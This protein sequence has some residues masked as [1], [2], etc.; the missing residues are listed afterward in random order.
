MRI[1]T[2][3]IILPLFLLLLAQYGWVQAAPSRYDCLVK[4]GNNA[5]KEDIDSCVRGDSTPT[6]SS[7]QTSS[8]DTNAEEATCLDLGFKKKTASYA[9]CVLELLERKENSTVSN[10]PDDATCRKYGFKRKTNEYAICRQQI[11]Q[12]R[13]QEKQRQAQFNAQQAQY[14]EQLAAYKKQKSEAAGL[15]LMGM[16][17][18][19]MSNT[20]PMY[21]GSAPIAPT[22]PQIGPRTYM[23]PGN[24]MMT[25]NTT[26]NITNCF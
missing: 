26:G 17:L 20:S 15:A 16:G 25:C 2:I 4:L 1:T 14:Q 19:M 8:I 24:K 3:K 18:G 10:D 9:N 22:A 13:T 7:G 21:G 12:A 11:D 23:L 5:S 6:Y